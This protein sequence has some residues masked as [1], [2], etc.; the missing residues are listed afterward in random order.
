MHED[1]IPGSEDD[2]DGVDIGQ[3]EAN[4]DFGG[5]SEVHIQVMHSLRKD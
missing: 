3:D 1:V 5:Y 2:V 4:H